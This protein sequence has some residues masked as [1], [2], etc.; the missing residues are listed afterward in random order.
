NDS[1]EAGIGILSTALFDWSLALA[2]GSLLA[3]YWLRQRPEIRIPKIRS[4]AILMAIAL[5]VQF[6][7]LV[8]S[9]TGQAGFGEVFA[10]APLVATTHAGGVALA[11]LG[12]VVL[13]LLADLR[14]PL[15]TRSVF[16]VLVAL[17][18]AFHAA[19]GHAAVG[20]DFS[21]AELLQ[22]LH[23]SGMAL[24]TGGVIVS[25]FY[26]V[27]R[28]I[29]SGGRADEAY[30]QSLSRVSTYSVAVVLLSGALKGWIGLE[31]HLSRLLHTGWGRIL[32]A[33][34]FFVALALALGWLHRRWIHQP[35]RGWTPQQAKTLMATLRVE[36]VCLTLVIALSAWLGS[37]DPSGS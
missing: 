34:L 22:F 18:L 6:Y 13:L 29:A 17:I 27:P 12:V 36:A 31:G 9:M 5:G 10:A 19:T 2:T 11:T 4:A 3:G 25:G 26:V 24:W 14:K 8:V 30:L 28:L 15:R 32:L 33:K 1:L 16:A 37:V 23:L 35:E 20:G 21:R 7:H